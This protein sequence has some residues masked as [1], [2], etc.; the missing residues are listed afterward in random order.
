MK[1]GEFDLD[2][3]NFG[4]GHPV[5]VLQW[6]FGLRD[7]DIQDVRVPNG[8]GLL[9]GR[10]FESAPEWTFTVR[11]KSAVSADAFDEFERM[12]RVWAT[13]YGPGEVSVLR[14]GLP[15]RVRR[16]VGR[17]R[18]WVPD[19]DAARQGIH[20]GRLS[21][22]ASFQLSDAR[23]FS[24][25]VSQVSLGLVPESSGGLVSPLVAPLTTTVRGGVRAGFVSNGG[26]APA[27]VTVKFFGPVSNPRV[28]TDGWEIGIAGNLAYDERITVDA[29]GLSVVNQGGASVGGRLTRGTRL[30]RAALVPGQSEIK[31][32]GGDSTGTARVEVSWRDAYYAF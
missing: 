15:G 30:R 24:D 8:N 18:R 4:C 13:E 21:G 14:Y 1:D 2:G 5:D 27:P 17:P 26:N 23:S 7:V 28:F 25:V 11:A 29:L 6:D 16:V 3:Y 31:F 12:R 32:T 19:K 10:D 22:L 9:M 20:I